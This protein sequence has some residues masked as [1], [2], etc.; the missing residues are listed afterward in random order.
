MYLWREQ[1]LAGALFDGEMWAASWE[2]GLRMARDVQALVGQE[3]AAGD[4]GGEGHAT[5][6]KGGK[7]L[8]ELGSWQRGC[9]VGSVLS[10]IR[11]RA[12]WHFADTLCIAGAAA[13]AAAGAAAAAR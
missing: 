12:W 8:C 13:A 4:E 1:V 3:D 11:K 9:G 2:R 6:Q 10:L 5:A 7:H